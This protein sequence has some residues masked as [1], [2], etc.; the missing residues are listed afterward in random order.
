MASS[1]SKGDVPALEIGGV[2]RPFFCSCEDGYDAADGFGIGEEI[3]DE[4]VA[5][6]DAEGEGVV[7]VF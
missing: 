6:V 3:L 7:E 5:A 1:F 4:A 2:D